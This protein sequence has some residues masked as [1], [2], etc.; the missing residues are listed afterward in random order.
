MLS[1]YLHMHTLIEAQ[2]GITCH[3]YPN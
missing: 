2:A 1:L 3:T